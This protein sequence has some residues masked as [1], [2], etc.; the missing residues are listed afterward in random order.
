MEVH[1][2]YL[3]IDV[4]NKFEDILV[5]VDNVFKLSESQ[6]VGYMDSKSTSKSLSKRELIDKYTVRPFELEQDRF[7]SAIKLAN[8]IDINVI[9]IE[10]DYDIDEELREEIKEKIRSN[11]YFKLFD[12][13]LEARS[14]GADIQALLFNFKDRDYRLTKYAIAEILGSLDEIPTLTSNSPIK[15]IL[16]LEKFPL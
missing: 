15:Y 10:F 14:E 4:H 9:D 1:N 2:V 13:V 5:P 16:G 3:Y 11:N 6:L 12:L 7:E 8:K